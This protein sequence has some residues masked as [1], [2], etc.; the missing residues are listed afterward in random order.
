LFCVFFHESIEIVISFHQ[1][2]QLEGFYF[3]R[4]IGD[5][6]VKVSIITPGA[7]RTGETNLKL[8]IE[9]MKQDW[10]ETP[11]HIKAAYGQRL[12]DTCKLFFFSS[13]VRKGKR[14]GE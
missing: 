2:T 11:A 10:E 9:K 1:R 6:G 13:C 4:E 5:F 3:R 12:F 8:S 14:I 7:F